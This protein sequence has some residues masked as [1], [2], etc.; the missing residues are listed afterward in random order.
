MRYR[1]KLQVQAW[2]WDGS[3]DMAELIAQTIR[4]VAFL[5]EID[6]GGTELVL[7]DPEDW[8]E[9]ARVRPGRYLVYSA[10]C[11]VHVWQRDAFEMVYEVVH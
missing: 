10:D 9:L 8:S 4:C 11:G 7:A 5:G 2:L 3:E 6:E 1:M